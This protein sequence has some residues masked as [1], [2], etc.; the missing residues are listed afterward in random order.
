MSTSK[1]S[2]AKVLKPITRARAERFL[3]DLANHNP[4]GDPLS[5]LL[6][7]VVRETNPNDQ[8]ITTEAER[9]KKLY[10]EMAQ[11][12]EGTFTIWVNVL[13]WTQIYLRRA[14]TASDERSRNWYLFEMRRQYHDAAVQSRDRR[15]GRGV[16][17]SHY[18]V[19]RLE[20]FVAGVPG[21]T[22]SSV[23][24]MGRALIDPPELTPFEVA[25]SYFQSRVG[26]RAKFCA[27]SGCWS[28]YFI[29]PPAKA[30]KYCSVKC[31]NDADAKNKHESYMRKKAGKGMF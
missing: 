24:R 11:P 4:I 1:K 21:L 25:A 15:A 26:H 9:V 13:Y 10:P 28:P 3:L 16:D 27:N 17:A 30:R 23:T 2:E 18:P 20:G 7:A 6:M 14:W 31:S 8:R 19:H 5:E 22:A 12:F 29:A